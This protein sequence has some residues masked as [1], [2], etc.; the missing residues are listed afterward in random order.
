MGRGEVPVGDVGGV[1]GGV[2]VDV[3][4]EDAVV[5]GAVPVVGVEGVAVVGD[6][7]DGVREDSAVGD[8]G[9]V[10]VDGTAVVVGGGVGDGV[11]GEGSVGS[12]SAAARAGALVTRRTCRR[13]I[14]DMADPGGF[15]S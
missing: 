12:V 8:D 1:G 9:A 4:G 14:L 2:P 3:V 7:V 15:A 13:L 10:V 11:P 5:V 6:V